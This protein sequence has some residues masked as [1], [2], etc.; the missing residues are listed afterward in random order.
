MSTAKST[1]TATAPSAE[2]P[3]S[4]P[5]PRP[6]G[7]SDPAQLSD[8]QAG[9]VLELLKKVDTVE[10]KVTIPVESHVATIRGLPL[11]PVEAQPRQ[12][13]FFD[14]PEL[15]LN[16]AGLIVRARRSAGGR[17]DTVVKLRPVEPDDL[18]VELRKLDSFNVEV[19]VLPGGFMCSASFKGG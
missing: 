6:A 2:K 10:L 9:K 5:S 19:D 1:S 15:A 3:P 8:E 17:G 11:D 13:Y 14:T 16:A 12:V 7:S 18:P 4:A